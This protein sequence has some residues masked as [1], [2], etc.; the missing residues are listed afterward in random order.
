MPA[1]DLLLGHRLRPDRALRGARRLRPHGAGHG[2]LHGPDRHRRRRA[3]SAPAC[4]SSDIFTGVYSVVG[5]LAALA[6]ARTHRPRLAMST[7]R[8]ST[9]RSACS[10]TRRSTISSP[11]KCPSASA[12]RIPTS[13][14]TRCFPVADGHIIIA[15]GNDNQFAKLCAVLGAPELAEEPNYQRQQDRLATPRRAGRATVRADR[16]HGRAPT[17]WPSSKPCRRAGRP[18][19]RARSGVCRSAGDPSRHA[20][21]PAERGAPRAEQSRACARRS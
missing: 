5:I 21:R 2:R 19:Q 6:R 8:W 1:P 3:A 16:A 13:C 18:D 9:S 4:R 12:M 11:A 7:P 14:P 15:T 17:C 10:P 20:A